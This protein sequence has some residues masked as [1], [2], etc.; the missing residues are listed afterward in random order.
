MSFK[1][2]S[3]MCDPT[4]FSGSE[5]LTAYKARTLSPVEVVNADLGHLQA[6]GSF[7]LAYRPC[8]SGMMPWTS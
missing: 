5:L 7:S 2:E 3:S 8:R 6:S 1:H 4:F